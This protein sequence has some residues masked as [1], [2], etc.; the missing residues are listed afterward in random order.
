MT[1]IGCGRIGE[2]TA[3]YAQ[4]FGMQVAAYDPYRSDM[5]PGVER[6]ATIA[7]AVSDADVVMVHVSL[8]AETRKLIGASEFRAM[9]RGAVLLNTA[10]GAVIDESALLAA[11]ASG[12]LSGAALDVLADEA[13]EALSRNSLIDWA[14]GH[15]NLLITPHIAG[16]SLDAMAATEIFVAEKLAEVLRMPAGPR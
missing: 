7:L 12:Q 5:P 9:K 16:A 11:L 4:A 14:R 6:R 2:K 13:P 1:I 15:D 3:I 10:R 8:T